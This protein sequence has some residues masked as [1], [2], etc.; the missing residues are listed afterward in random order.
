[1]SSWILFPVCHIHNY[2]TFGIPAQPKPAKRLCSATGAPVDLEFLRPSPVSSGPPFCFPP[3]TA[4]QS[5]LTT[6]STPFLLCSDL[7]C[8]SKSRSVPQRWCLSVS[9]NPAEHLPAALQS[10]A[11]GRRHSVWEGRGSSMGVL[12]PASALPPSFSS[13]FAFLTCVIVRR[14]ALSYLFPAQLP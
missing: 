1:M 12:P 13:S 4:Q 10:S 3:E 5:S 11:Q 2:H 9:L 6:Q 8:L 7:P 14:L